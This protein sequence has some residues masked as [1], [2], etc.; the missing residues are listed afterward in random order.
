M[1]ASLTTGEDDD[2]ALR[3][4]LVVDEL[5]SVEWRSDANRNDRLLSRVRR[6]SSGVARGL[7]RRLA[8]PLSSMCRGVVVNDGV[9]AVVVTDATEL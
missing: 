2:T 3:S 4:S 1:E 9:T 8:I 6:T 5:S 7:R